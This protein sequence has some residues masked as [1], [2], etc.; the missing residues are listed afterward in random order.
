VIS[1][2]SIDVEAQEPDQPN[3]FSLQNILW[4]IVAGLIILFFPIYLFATSVQTD[5]VQL[6]REL[7][8]LLST[9]TAVSPQTNNGAEHA[10]QL[11]EIQAQAAQFSLVIPTLAAENQDWPA[12]FNLIRTYD[13]SQMGL[14]A[15][16]QSGTQLTITGRAVDDAIVISYARQLENSGQFKSV[17]VHSIVL[18]DTPFGTPTPVT[19]AISSITNAT[20]TRVATAVPTHTPTRLVI[21][22]PT[23]TPTPD[24]R[25]VYEWDDTVPKPIFLGQA[26]THNFCPNFDVD[27]VT[28]LAKAGRTYQISTSNLAPGV[29]TFLTVT[30]GETSLTNDDAEIGTLASRVTMQAPPDQ[31]IDVV[32]R[33]SNRG[34]YGH[35]FGYQ[36]L[37][38]E[39]VPTPTPTSMATTPTSTPTPTQTPT[40]T[41]DLRDV[42]EPDDVNP[43]IISAGESQ[44]H[45]FYPHGDID[46]I[47][48]SVKRGHHYQLLTSNLAVGV[49]TK[50]AVTLGT[51]SWENDDYDK[52]GSGNYASAVCFAAAPD[53]PAN[54]AALITLT[55]VAQQFAPNRMYTISV[56]E[57]PDLIVN[58]S[59]INFGQVPTDTT[60]LLTQPIS[61]GASNVVTW[62]A[63]TNTPWLS[64]DVPTG[65]TPA[66][67]T[68]SANIAGLTVGVHE[69]ELRLRWATYCYRTFPVTI[70]L[71]PVSAAL[72]FD[73][74]VSP[75]TRWIAESDKPGHMVGKQ[76]HYQGTHA[77]EFIIIVELGE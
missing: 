54:A 62:T 44:T 5:V 4:L 53:L 63:V 2:E 41:P 36:V 12:A 18:V 52:T 15:V 28:F 49:D 11:S 33:I 56:N 58:P 10:P 35:E 59:P 21:S 42:Y 61:L 27:N 31:D 70:E 57:V 43:G 55:N 22:G 77:V 6:E 34:P 64:I 8:P 65:T 37:V 19:T 13:A 75:N 30:F 48:L 51:E 72:P 25:D 71:V 74:A 69:G 7:A 24:L 3:L 17:L 66:Q 39:V 50:M 73:T 67:F 68:L 14:T 1:Q 9:L 76:T 26:Q 16:S 32:V 40:P 23:R 29:D 38:Q 45:T 47:A 20:A 60:T 46:K